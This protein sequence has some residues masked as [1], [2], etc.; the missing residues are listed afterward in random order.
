MSNEIQ[1]RI[2]E[3]QTAYHEWLS[4]QEK[5]ANTHQ[6]WQKSVELMQKMQDFYLNGEYQEIY[7]KIENGEKLDLTTQGEYS[8]MSED[9][10]WDAMHEHD[11]ALWQMLRFAVKHLDKE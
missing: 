2:N 11:Q 1:N 10:L 9:A 7:E 6:D 8:I 5:L 4:L 3:I